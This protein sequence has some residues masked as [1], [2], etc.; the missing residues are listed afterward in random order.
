VSAARPLPHGVVASSVTPF[1]ADGA[2]DLARLGPHIDW[3][4]S[5]GVAG[6][7]PLGSSGEFFALETAD[8]MRVAEAALEATAGRVH[9]MVGTHHYSTRIAIELSRHAERAGADSLLVVPPYYGL[10]TP[11]GV[12]DHYRRIAEAVSIPLVLYHNA[13]GTNVDVTTDQLLVLFREGAIRGVK[14]SHLLPDRMVELL[15]ADLPEGA[16]IYAGIDYVAFEG[17][18]HGA[19][20]WISAIPSMTPRVAAH[21]YQTLGLRGDLAGAREQWRRLAPLMRF[22]FGASHI[23]RGRGSHWAAIMKA[24][25]S[26]IGPDVGLPLPPSS[27]LAPDAVATLTGLLRDLGYEIDPAA[28]VRLANRADLAALAN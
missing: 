8:R 10:P 4:I 9:T 16:R 6:L 14:M 27:P 15:Q 26:L 13:A 21:F 20:G 25:L 17:L 12:L 3:L 5:E 11:E 1:T 28:T 18:A 7:S 2:L 23:S 24:G 22:V 19:H